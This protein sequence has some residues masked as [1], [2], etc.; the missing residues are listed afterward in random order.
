M[1]RP[2]ANI[3]AIPPVP[4]SS[5]LHNEKRTVLADIEAREEVKVLILPNPDMDTP[6]YDVQRLREDHIEDEGEQDKSSFELSVD[7]DIG[8]EPDLS[9]AKPV[10]RTEAAVKTVIHNEPAPASLR[11]DPSPQPKIGRAHV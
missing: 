2:N 8:K 10:S 3:R 1:K 11:Q 4:M 9:V 6:H 7:T 5:Y